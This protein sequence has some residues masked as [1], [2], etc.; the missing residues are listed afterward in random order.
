MM[1][2]STRSYGV[3]ACTY[4]TTVAMTPFV[5]SNI[6]PSVSLSARPAQI[7]SSGLESRDSAVLGIHPSPLVSSILEL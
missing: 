4:W 5:H 2:G 3:G 7:I 1:G 6:C